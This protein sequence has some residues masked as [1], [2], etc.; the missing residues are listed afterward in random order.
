M[1]SFLIQGTHIMQQYDIFFF[2]FVSYH[3][4]ASWS[5]RSNDV[6]ALL[7]TM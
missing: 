6:I 4:N 1:I 7:F 5:P 2:F 3:D